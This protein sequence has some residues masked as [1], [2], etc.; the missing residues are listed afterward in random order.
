MTTHSRRDFLV[1]SAAAASMLA[2]RPDRL[3]AAQAPREMAI[4]RWGRAKG[5]TQEQLKAL[6][7]EE[8]KQMGVKLTEKALE[9]IGGLKRFVGRGSVVWI[10]PNIGWDRSP[11]QAAN[12]NPD[13]VATVVRLCFEAGAKTV[14]VGDNPCDLAVKSYANSGIA[15][16]ARGAGAEVLMLDRTRFK[17]TAVNGERVKSIPIFPGILECDLVINIPVVKHHVLAT[18]TLCMKNYMGVIENR[19]FFHQDIPT[20]LADI[21]RF[22][23]PRICI[24]DGIRVLTAHGP[25]GGKLEDVAVKATVAAG[26]DI[27]ALDS[28]GAELLGKQRAEIK[29]ISI[30][31]KAGLGKADYR[32]LALEEITV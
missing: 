6:P 18:G 13:L 4:A 14:K 27:V 3:L 21:T 19:R 31:E 29:S 5:M 22:M 2:V 9:A 32:S 28:F 17:E 25:K 20:C 10:K 30:G 1:H 8:F 12:T 11:E 23:K 7:A 24:L 26:T 16:A 15:D